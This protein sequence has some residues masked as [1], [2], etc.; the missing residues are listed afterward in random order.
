M[1]NSKIGLCSEKKQ[2][3]KTHIRS[4]WEW[5]SVF[6]FVVCRIPTGE[7]SEKESYRRREREGGR[8]WQGMIERSKAREKWERCARSEGGE[9]ATLR[10]LDGLQP[11]LSRVV[12]LFFFFLFLIFCF[13]SILYTKTSSASWVRYVLFKYIYNIWYVYYKFRAL[14]WHST[15][16]F[17]NKKRIVFFNGR[18][19]INVVAAKHNS[20]NKRSGNFRRSQVIFQPVLRSCN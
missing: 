8:V 15:G 6:S 5:L 19:S 17:K 13:S 9:G 16:V 18:R 14:Y 10:A 12:T 2:K 20:E 11:A 1:V 3:K 4:G 7:K